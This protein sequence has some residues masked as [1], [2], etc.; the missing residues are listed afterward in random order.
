[1]TSRYP[2]PEPGQ[3]EPRFRP[4]WLCLKEHGP[5]KAIVIRVSP[6]AFLGRGKERMYEAWVGDRKIYDPQDEFQAGQVIRL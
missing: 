1:M 6:D 2:E 3:W 4:S 5:N